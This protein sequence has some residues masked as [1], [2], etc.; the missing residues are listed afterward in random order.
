MIEYGGSSADPT[1]QISASRSVTIDATVPTVSGVGSS[2]ADG[3]YKI[4]DVVSIQVGFS[5]SVTVTGTPQLTL[6][7]GATDR[8]INYVSGSG[9]SSLTFTYTV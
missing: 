7:T 4:G 5:E 1:V 9:S 2:T 6:E 3:T 8:T